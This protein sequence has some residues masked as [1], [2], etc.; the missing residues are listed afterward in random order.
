MLRSANKASEQA[1]RVVQPA[2]VRRAPPPLPK[3]RSAVAERSDVVD[4][5]RRRPTPRLLLPISAPI[6]RPQVAMRD[7]VLPPVSD[8]FVRQFSLSL[9]PRLAQELSGP[10]AAS[11]RVAPLQAGQNNAPAANGQAMPARESRA[12]DVLGFALAWLMTT[13]RVAPL[14]AGQ[15]N[16][17]AAIGPAT[18]RRESRAGDVLGFALAWLMATGAAAVVA[19]HMIARSQSPLVV[20]VPMIPSSS[21]PESA[22]APSSCPKSWEPPTMAVNDL[23]MMPQGHAAESDKNANHPLAAKPREEA[24]RPKAWASLT[25]RTRSAEVAMV[26]PATKAKG[27]SKSLE[28]WM[29][30]SVQPR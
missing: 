21:T 11:L 27:S 29:R 22:A 19:G 20:R 5:S 28:D 9:A 26:S 1:A 25:H 4:S 12:G 13:L 18:A 14:Q 8:D 23:P 7:S 10:G 16:A 2:P 30:A 6:P 3:K 15:N 17:P 24:P